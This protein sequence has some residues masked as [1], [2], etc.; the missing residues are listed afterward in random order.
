MSRI[1]SMRKI[2]ECLILLS[3]FGRSVLYSPNRCNYVP[4]ILSNGKSP[5]DGRFVVRLD[6]NIEK[7]VSGEEYTSMNNSI[8]YYIES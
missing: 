1:E 8:F 3:L 5:A 7:Y 4:D 6:G 2:L